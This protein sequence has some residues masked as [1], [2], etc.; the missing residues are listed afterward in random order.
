MRHLTSI[1]AVNHEG[2]IG[3]GNA[4][5]WRVKSDMA[6]FRQ[7][8]TGSCVIMGRTTFDSLGRLPLKGRFNIV[9]THNPAAIPTTEN[10]QAVGCIDEAL[11][12]RSRIRVTSDEDFVIG[13]ASI[14]AAFAGIVDRYYITMVDHPA[15]E[16]D[17]FLPVTLFGNEEEW[18][19]DLLTTGKANGQDDQADFAIFALNNKRAEARAHARQQRANQFK[20]KQVTAGLA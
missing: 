17:A 8:T 4:L 13:G 7:Q 16:G 18:S 11:H 14:Y 10:L 20:L 9:L 19:L 3:A 15:P 2:V 6:F 5:P 1:V 12:L